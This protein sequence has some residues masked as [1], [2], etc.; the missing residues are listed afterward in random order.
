M[1]IK[2]YDYIPYTNF[3]SHRFNA[4]KKIY[5]ID[6]KMERMSGLEFKYIKRPKPKKI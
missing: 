3:Y 4:I 1:T 2:N 6:K 5:E